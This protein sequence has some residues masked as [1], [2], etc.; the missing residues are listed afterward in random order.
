MAVTYT[1]AVKDSML[2]ALITAMGTAGKLEIGTAGMAATLAT[3]T[4]DNPAGATSNGVLTLAFVASTVAAS[5]TGL[6]AAAIPSS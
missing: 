5:G 4:L 2:G 1:N 3:F 6:A